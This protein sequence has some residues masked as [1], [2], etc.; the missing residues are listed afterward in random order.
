LRYV[1]D[2]GFFYIDAEFKMLKGDR[3]GWSSPSME[4]WSENRWISAQN[5]KAFKN[6]IFWTKYWSL[7][8]GVTN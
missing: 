7:G 8:R 4:V 3:S 1:S 6:G 2:K 5:I